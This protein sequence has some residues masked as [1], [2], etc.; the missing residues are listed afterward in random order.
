M[1]NKGLIREILII[2]IALIILGYVFHISII[3]ILNAPQVQSNLHWAW[4]IVTTV[5]SWISAP[6]MYIWNNFVIGVIWNAIQAG[7]H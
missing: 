3:D 2:I 5:W 4:N 7:L 6:I 1:Y